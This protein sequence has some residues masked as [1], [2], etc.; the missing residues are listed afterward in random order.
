MGLKKHLVQTA[1]FVL[2]ACLVLQCV[3]IASAVN[4]PSSGGGPPPEKMPRYLELVGATASHMSTRVANRHDSD[5]RYT[6]PG[7]TAA[8]VEI[9][10]PMQEDDDSRYCCNFDA[11]PGIMLSILIATCYGCYSIYEIHIEVQMS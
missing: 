6:V 4:F 3:L 9:L 5:G 11:S 8:V 10:A 1:T 2:F 7:P